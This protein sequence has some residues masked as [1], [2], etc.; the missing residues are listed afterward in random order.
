MD[1]RRLK[2]R[3]C[4][5]RRPL[6]SHKNNNLKPVDLDPGL[7]THIWQ[8]VEGGEKARV[9]EED[10]APSREN[11]RRQKPLRCSQRICNFHPPKQSLQTDQEWKLRFLN[12]LP[13][14]A[15]LTEGQ[16]LGPRTAGGASLSEEGQSNPNKR[17]AEHVSEMQDR[18]VVLKLGLRAAG[19]R[20]STAREVSSAYV[21]RMSSFS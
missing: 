20:W 19:P 21:D 4:Q 7:R 1:L 12:W 13:R 10:D 15:W 8:P 9:P 18:A 11:S 6:C 5:M 14:T 2:G 3:R 16:L 17:A